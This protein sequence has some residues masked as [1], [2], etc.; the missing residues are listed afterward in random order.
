MIDRGPVQASRRGATLLPVLFLILLPSLV[1]IVPLAYARPSDPTWIAGIYHDA[2]YD[3]VAAH[4]TEGAA[5]STA[6]RLARVKEGRELCKV[7]LERSQVPGRMLRAD[8]SRGPP[9]I[10][11]GSALRSATLSLC[12]SIRQTVIVRLGRGPPLTNL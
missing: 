7:L 6:E 2:D 10:E 8:V 12:T 5:A 11:L 9:P 1:A 3:D 4:V